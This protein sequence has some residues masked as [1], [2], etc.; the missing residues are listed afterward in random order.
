MRNYRKGSDSEIRWQ[1][2]TVGAI[3]ATPASGTNGTVYAGSNNAYMYALHPDGTE[4][5]RFATTQALA[6]ESASRRR[7]ANTR[8]RTLIDG[9]HHCGRVPTPLTPCDS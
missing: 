7:W 3:Y 9:H 4:A 6:R 2:R 8:K 1:V 5:W